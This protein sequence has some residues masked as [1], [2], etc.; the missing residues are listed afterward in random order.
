VKHERHVKYVDDLR[1]MENREVDR[2]G[3]AMSKVFT[4]LL[5]SADGSPKRFLRALDAIDK[6]LVVELSKALVGA[7]AK[8]RKVGKALGEEKLA[9][10]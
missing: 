8:S 3:V 9:E 6:G 5:K 1:E 7:S 10:H 4:A 2:I